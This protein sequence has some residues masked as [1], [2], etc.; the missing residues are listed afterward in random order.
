[1]ANC[2]NFKITLMNS[3]HGEIKV[4]KFEYKD[5]SKWE[6]ETGMFGARRPPE[7]RRRARM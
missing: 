4:T 7:D 1:M 5:G 6:A 3:T 2:G